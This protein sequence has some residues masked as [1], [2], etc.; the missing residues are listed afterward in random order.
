MQMRST[1]LLGCALAS[2]AGS[3]CGLL[4]GRTDSRKTLG[5][6]CYELPRTVSGGCDAYFAHGINNCNQ[7]F[8]MCTDPGT[9]TVCAN[10]VALVP[11]NGKVR[12]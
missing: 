9:G 12:S 11:P 5:L 6:W 4:V 1:V 8:N 2:V 10:D 3:Q 7:P